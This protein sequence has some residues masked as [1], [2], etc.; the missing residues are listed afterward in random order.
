MPAIFTGE[1][2]RNAAV[3]DAHQHALLAA[4]LAKQKAVS[5]EHVQAAMP[6][7]A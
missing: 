4:A 3:P 1:L 5:I 6:E 7:V 2:H